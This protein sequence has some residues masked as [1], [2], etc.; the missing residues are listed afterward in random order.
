M[1]KEM[2]PIKYGQQTLVGGLINAPYPRDSGNCF[3]LVG[4][5]SVC[6]MC[7]ENL[8]EWQKRTGT[9]E[10]EVALFHHRGRPYCF[11][12]DE[13]IDKDWFVKTYCTTCFGGLMARV[14]AIAESLGLEKPLI[15]EKFKALEKG[16]VI[17]DYIP[18]HVRD[19]SAAD[20]IVKAV[21]MPDGEGCK[22]YWSE[23]PDGRDFDCF[24]EF[25]GEVTCDHCIFGAPG[26]TVD[27]Q[28][29]PNKEE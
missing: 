13:R 11:I 17:A 1:K 29:D 25:A 24:Y 7:V 6:N 15:P 12:T 18:I 2:V 10:V 27:P 23:G 20:A 5:G 21:N 8:T 19:S 14:L 22:G 26:G 16:P 4:A 28:V 3:E 9:K